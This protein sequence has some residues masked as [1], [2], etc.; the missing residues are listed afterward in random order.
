MALTMLVVN[1]ADEFLHE[2]GVLGRIVVT[3]APSSEVIVGGNARPYACSR[4]PNRN[5]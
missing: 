4:M 3:A 1:Q 5:L 2:A